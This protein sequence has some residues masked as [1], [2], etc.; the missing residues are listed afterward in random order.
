MGSSRQSAT[1]LSQ[2]IYVKMRRELFGNQ[3][4][5]D[6]PHVT[7]HPHNYNG[8]GV[9]DRHRE[10]SDGTSPGGGRKS[11]RG[12]LAVWTMDAILCG[13]N[14]NL[15]GHSMVR[16]I[17][18]SEVVGCTGGDSVWVKRV[19]MDEVRPELVFVIAA[20]PDA[21]QDSI[22]GTKARCVYGTCVV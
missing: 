7:R 1:C 20:N 17:H 8:A 19:V 13:M 5:R 18:M 14:S 6:S 10:V 15:C 11:K 21:A 22:F 12:F 4:H 3:L 9:T 16:S 2:S